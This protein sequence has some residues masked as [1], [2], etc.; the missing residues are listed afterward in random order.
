MNEID[1]ALRDMLMHIDCQAKRYAELARIATMKTR[2]AEKLATKISIA[3]RP[4]LKQ[5]ILATNAVYDEIYE[6]GKIP[7]KS[8]Y[9]LVLGQY[10]IQQGLAHTS[11]IAHALKQSR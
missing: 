8:L 10:L 6:Q 4:L 7:A 11:E 5:T 1:T 2:D 9:Y 3:L